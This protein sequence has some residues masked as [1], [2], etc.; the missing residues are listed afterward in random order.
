MGQETAPA[1]DPLL[2][3][4]KL[5]RY[6]PAAGTKGSPFYNGA[7]AVEGSV[8]LRGEVFLPVMLQYNLEDQQLILHY[9]T[10]DGGVSQI[11]VS[12]AWLESFRLGTDYFERARNADSTFAIYQIIEAGNFRLACHYI[13]R[14]TL[15][16]SYGSRNYQY[17]EPMR[18]LFLVRNQGLQK[19]S[20]NRGFIRLQDETVQAEIRKFLRRNHI[21]VNKASTAKLQALADFCNSITP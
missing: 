4:G 8:T 2:Y 21:H 9:K 15:E 1:M 14:R 3:N 13:V 17:S 20:G 5:Y 12:D 19:F 6:V 10:P 16:T 7:N 11:V 18:S